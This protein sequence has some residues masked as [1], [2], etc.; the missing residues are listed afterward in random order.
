METNRARK[1]DCEQQ[2]R[3]Y[4]GKEGEEFDF[5]CAI[6]G[7]QLAGVAIDRGRD[8]CRV[9]VEPHHIIESVRDLQTLLDLSDSE[10]N[11]ELVFPDSNGFYVVGRAPL[12]D[13]QT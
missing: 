4:R 12:R 3:V 7:V 8:T 6:P 13:A 9:T 10:K 2:V 11:R 5:R 1:A